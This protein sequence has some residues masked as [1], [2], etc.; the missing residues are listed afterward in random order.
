MYWRQ[1]F[2]MA[3]HTL[4]SLSALLRE[5]K[6]KQ[7]T[8][9]QTKNKTNH[10]QNIHVQMHDSFNNNDNVWILC[11]FASGASLQLFQTDFLDYT[12]KASILPH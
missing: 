1:C 4:S 7:K 8:N 5:Q 9:K 6:T 11:L 12:L 2:R 10:Q 3:R